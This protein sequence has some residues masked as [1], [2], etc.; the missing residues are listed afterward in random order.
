MKKLTQNKLYLYLTIL[1][2]I[3]AILAI[4]LG[5]IFGVKKQ[6]SRASTVIEITFHSKH[7][8][9]IAKKKFKL[10]R[11]IDVSFS[12]QELELEKDEE[13]LGWSAKQNNKAYI[14]ELK[15]KKEYTK[16]YPVFKK[17]TKSSLV[18]YK[19]VHFLEK[20]GKESQLDNTYEKIEEIMSNQKVED[21]ANYSDYTNL[22]KTLY[23]K[24]TT[25]SENKLTAELKAGDNSVEVRQYYKLKEV[26]VKFKRTAGIDTLSYETLKVKKTRSIALPNYTLKDTHNFIGWAQ[27]QDGA[28][29]TEFI[30]S[31]DVDVLELYARTDYQDREITYTIKKENVDGSFAETTE[32]KSGKIAST[33]TVEY[34][35]PNNT[36]WQKPIYSIE[37]LTINADKTQNKITIT[38][39]RKVFYITFEVKD[40]PG[41]FEKERKI[42]YG[43]KIGMIDASHFNE[44]GLRITKIELDGV[45]KSKNEIENFVVTENYHITIYVEE[46]ARLFGKYPQTKVD[47]PVGIQLEKEDQRELKFNSKGTDYTL[48]FA[49]HYYKDVDGNRY[50]MYNGSYFKFEDVEFLKIPKQK[51]WFTKKIIDFTPF[52]LFI[53]NHSDNGKPEHSIF[54]AMIEDIGKLLGGDVYM[55]SYDTGDFQIKP[56][57]DN[58]LQSQL[59]KEPTDYAKAVLNQFSKNQPYY[60]GADLSVY[61]NQS[62]YPNYDSSGQQRWWL[63]TQHNFSF[64][65]AKFI[66]SMGR[67]GFRNVHFVYGVVVCIR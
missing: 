25:H 57:L 49:R 65:S 54:K 22:D 44:I 5:I 9:E 15:A 53:S 35:N 12:N 23:E 64:P 61:P 56:A 1:V 40:H 13:F 14:S 48:N 47:N 27:T 6:I 42:R 52:N 4:I 24:D 43:A 7:G 21:G 36:V 62:Q 66:Q 34:L 18:N 33:H 51:T 16:L 63:A 3:V 29:Q 8:K 2:L 10:D 67:L 28:V 32:T 58:N 60:R 39:M 38:L 19:I 55:P 59:V 31:K 37:K 26:E 50:E 46:T 45:L 30:A 20:Q 41:T 17:N 11:K